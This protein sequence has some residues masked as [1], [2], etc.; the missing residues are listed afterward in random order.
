MQA[1]KTTSNADTVRAI[2]ESFG[3][4][5]VP[6]ILA[7]VTDDVDWN[8]SGTAAGN[9]PWNGNFSGRNKLPGFFAA[10]AQHL[11]IPLFE[12]K[13]FVSEGRHVAV[14]LRIRLVM[15]K[16]GKSAE[17]DTIHYWTLD[18]HGK[19]SAYRHFNDTAGE[20]AAWRG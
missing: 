5:D 14:R 19:V 2:Y 1:S 7:R 6:S 11:D 13:E 15:K 16:N 9:L 8:N 20:L 10:L 18:G 4:G 17:F 12:P 3:R